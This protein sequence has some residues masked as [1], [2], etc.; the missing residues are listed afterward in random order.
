MLQRRGEIRSHGLH[1]C[2]S[3]D[4]PLGKLRAKAYAAPGMFREGAYHYVRSEGFC[5]HEWSLDEGDDLHDI[6]FGQAR[7]SG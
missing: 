2:E 3:L 5:L 7:K 4:T 1:C 6:A